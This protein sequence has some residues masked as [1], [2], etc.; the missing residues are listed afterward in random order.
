MSADKIPGKPKLLDCFVY[1]ELYASDISQYG[2]VCK[3]W[4]ELAQVFYI[5]VDRCAQKDIVAFCYGMDIICIFS[6][7]PIGDSFLECR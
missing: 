4:L 6:Q 3:K 7:C 5:I 1:V 2:A